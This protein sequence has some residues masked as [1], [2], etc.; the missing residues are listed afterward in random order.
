MAPGVSTL[1][2]VGPGDVPT[3]QGL[4][5][6]I[7]NAGN[8]TGQ[9]F[10]TGG[11]GNFNGDA[12]LFVSEDGTVSGWRGAL[13]TTAE[14]LVSPSSANSYKGTAIATIGGNSYLYSANFAAGTID[15][16][17]ETQGAAAL[18]ELRGPEHPLG[19]RSFQYPEPR[20]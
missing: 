13:G 4:V 2:R 9:V 8:V 20:R 3:K 6:T 14:T 11:T 1:Y 18:G 15:V 16:L 5:V 7:P 19:I 10:N 12:F 17:R